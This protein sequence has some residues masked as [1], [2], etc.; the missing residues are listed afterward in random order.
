[1]NKQTCPIC[2]NEI[3]KIYIIEF[4]DELNDFFATGVIDIKK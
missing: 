4:D 3:S 2:R 1:M